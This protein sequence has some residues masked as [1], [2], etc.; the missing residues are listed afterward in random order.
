MVTCCG[1][2]PRKLRIICSTKLLRAMRLTMEADHSTS[3]LKNELIL[4]R[5]WTVLSGQVLAGHGLR[6]AY[7]GAP[8][9]DTD[10]QSATQADLEKT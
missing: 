5:K 8:L 1:I 10:A 4:S 3:P 6:H 7:E 9:G 2:G